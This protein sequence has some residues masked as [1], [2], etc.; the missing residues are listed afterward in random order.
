MRTVRLLA[1]LALAGAVSWATLDARQRP[2]PPPPPAPPLPMPAILARYPAVTA[3]R[4]LHPADG[5]W[6]SIRRTYDGWGYSPLD[7]ITPA[8]VARLRPVWIASTGATNG[9]EAPALVNG[10]V[11]FVATP[12]NQVIALEA[13][14]GRVLWRYRRPIP[15]DAVVMHPTSR[16]V[17]LYGGKVYLA[18]NEGVLVALDARTGKEVWTADVGGNTS[19]YYM[20]LAPLVAEGKVMIGASGGEFG[21]RGFVAAFDAETG[22]PAWKTYTVPAPGEPGSETWPTGDQ[23]KTGGAPV[24][25]TGNYDPASRLAY[26]GTGNGGPWMGDQRP[27]DNL[28]TASTI[29]V[30]VTT[31]RIK[32]HFQ[33]H[34]N[35]SWD[36]DEVSPPIL[37]D[38]QRGGRTVRGL[39]N[40]ARDGYLWFLDRGAAG[41]IG[42]VE[43]TPYVRQTVFRGLDP[44]TG[45]PDVD[46]ARKPGT[47]KKVENVC[48][49]H[50]GGKNWPPIAF[51]P[52]TRLIYIPANENLCDWLTGTEVDYEP[53]ER[54]IGATS[55]MRLFEGADH[56]G[57]VQ[58]WHVDTGKRVWTHA[59]P[60]SPTWGSMLATGGGLVFT[61]G[62]N[63]RML[64]AFDAAT[65][66]LV[67]EFPTNSGILSPPSSFSIDGKQ[68]IAVQSGWG[69]DSRGMQS[70]LNTLTNGAYPEVPEGGAIWV[71]ALP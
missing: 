68:Y 24:W 26:W 15:E 29:A 8:N 45:R 59:Y 21:I 50:W 52:K 33:Y 18:A 31:G 16:G 64:H 28:Y 58:A 56:V 5:E 67:W 6:L 42:F 27:G 36:W 46:P 12:G 60:T 71:F 57:E 61:G 48:P 39:V 34:P 62:T 44:K 14:T 13:T 11:M 10:G 7:Q 51:S 40:V 53:G 4:L 2:A 30:D 43:G 19:G 9:H 63:D 70:R 69:I 25:V 35:D 54:F 38:Y 55:G 49:S 23:W 66:A 32:G 47:G 41:P 1:A 17:A 37:V 20:T 3:E 65:G 22:A